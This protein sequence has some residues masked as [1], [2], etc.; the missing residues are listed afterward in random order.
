MP[1]PAMLSHVSRGMSKQM[2]LNYGKHSLVPARAEPFTADQNHRMLSMTP[3]TLVNG[4]TYEPT[5]AFWRG[6]RLLDTFANQ[7]GERKS[8][9][10][11]HEL[12]EYMRADVIYS[13][14]EE[15][16]QTRTQAPR[17]CAPSDSILPI[18]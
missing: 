3:G 18:A 4:R 16:H 13:S 12:G 15:L 14:L 9:I 17:S 5:T 7:A 10:I 1:S 8:G 2:L 6:W 11:G